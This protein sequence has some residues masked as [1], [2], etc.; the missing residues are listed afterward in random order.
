LVPAEAFGI[1][2]ADTKA[3]VKNDFWISMMVGSD[4]GSYPVSGLNQTI[5]KDCT[6]T[7]IGD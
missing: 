7:K 3:A 6:E 5:P 1:S 4:F 2:V